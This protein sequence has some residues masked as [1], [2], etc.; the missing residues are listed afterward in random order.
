M[1]KPSKPGR[2]NRIEEQIQRDLASLIP[3][4]L[5]D[6]RIGLVTITGVK[7]TPDY[8]HATVYFTS[9]GSTPEA[10]EEA[11]NNASPILH[12][13]IFKLL[14]I[15]TVPQL[16]FVYDKSVEEGFEMDQLI[17]KARAEDAE[18]IKE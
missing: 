5:S 16:H 10:S 11:L 9:I 15:H 13:R 4:E 18:K 1:I 14:K 2:A 17:K 7:I 6:K 12:Q 8:A 3:K